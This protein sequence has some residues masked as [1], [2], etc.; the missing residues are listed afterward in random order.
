[1][2]YKLKRGGFC[3]ALVILG[4]ASAG[5]VAYQPKPIT[6]SAVMGDFEARRLDAPELKDFLQARHGVND[7]PPQAWDLRTLTLAAFYYNPDLDVA[8]AQWGTAQAGR[9]TAGERPN[10][11]LGLLIGYNTTSP[12]SEVTPWIPEAALDIPIETAGKRGYRIDQAHHLSDAARLN[13]WTATWNVRSRLRQAYLDLYSAREMDVLLA[14]LLAIQ[15]ENVRILDAQLAVGEASPADVTQARLALDAGRLAA[16]DAANQAAAARVRLASAVGVPAAAL[17]GITVSFDVLARIKPDLPALEIRRRALVSRTDILGALSEYEAAQS[18]LRL[19]IAKQYPD[20]ALG[21]A[22]Q[23]DQTDA[24]WTLGLSLI[25]PL[26]SRNK[27]PIA[28][29]DARRTEAAARFLAL[30]AKVIGDLESALT[31]TRSAADKAQA[32]DDMLLN[33]GKQ[34]AAARAR[35]SLGDIS[36][37]ELLG[38]QLE[39][40]A[41]ALARLDAVVKAQQAAGDLE[42]AMQSPLDIKEWIL[43]TPGRTAGQAKERK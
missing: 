14:R 40:A 19:E 5:C 20:I 35:Y 25:L 43:E 3:V 7:W 37:L 29:A 16:I 8:R 12:V 41:G 30:Q 13:I 36:K 26:F 15:T 42:N 23:L 38:L 24:K 22:F 31:A 2:V 17:E 10:P 28:E 9:I 1:V 6:A 11:A 27:G 34:E 39:H 18:A 32:A 21:P 4:L 33:L